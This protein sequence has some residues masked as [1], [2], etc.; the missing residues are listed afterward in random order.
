MDYLSLLATVVAIIRD[1]SIILAII[2][3]RDIVAAL[4]SVGEKEGG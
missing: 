2:H 1:F 4:K 3:W